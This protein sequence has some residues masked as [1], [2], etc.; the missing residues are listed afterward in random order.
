MIVGCVAINSRSRFTFPGWAGLSPS[1][2]STFSVPR[3]PPQ[4]SPP[5]SPHGVRTGLCVF[6]PRCAPPSWRLLAPMSWGCG[7]TSVSPPDRAP[8]LCHQPSTYQGST[9]TWG[10]SEHVCLRGGT[11]CPST[12][13]WAGPDGNPSSASQ[14]Q[15]RFPPD[16]RLDSRV[17]VP[18]PTLRP[19]PWLSPSME[20]LGMAF[21]GRGLGVL[22]VGEG[23]S[24]ARPGDKAST[25]CCPLPT[26]PKP[27]ST[28]PPGSLQG[29]FM[30]TTASPSTISLWAWGHAGAA[31][32][33][34]LLLYLLCPPPQHCSL[35]SN[36][37]TASF[38]WWG[39]RG[40]ERLSN[41]PKATQEVEEA[42]LGFWR[43]G[44]ESS[45]FPTTSGPG[46]SGAPLRF[47]TC[48]FPENH[49]R[50]SFLRT[51]SPK[52]W[53]PDQ[54]PML[55]SAA[56]MGWEEWASQRKSVHAC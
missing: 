55:V 53:V 16:D 18:L 43:S 52:M 42:G 31:L 1:P 14:H 45:A 37:T 50:A 11:I 48:S 39:N 41:L 54:T 49:L 20:P 30:T 24:W 28:P 13:C 44:S 35:S 40:S 8:P 10:A 2:S 27:V 47:S 3:S 34:W 7:I 4:E 12:T 6:L 56:S 33:S 46:D 38:Y 22:G 26:A 5:G 19:G 23:E 21:P 51:W 25:S 15:A 9:N 32:E 17:L 36:S 29:S